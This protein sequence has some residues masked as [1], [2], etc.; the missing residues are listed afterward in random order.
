[1]QC[2][3]LL[4]LQVPTN[5]NHRGLTATE[6]QTS[7]LEHWTVEARPPHNQFQGRGSSCQ[8]CGIT[9]GASM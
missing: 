3:N 4:E 6:D 8:I 5:Q 9:N 2:L 1:M 7:V